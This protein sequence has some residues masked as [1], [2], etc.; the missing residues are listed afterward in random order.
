M[1]GKIFH[2]Y[3]WWFVS[4]WFHLNQLIGMHVCTSKYNQI[5]KSI[6]WSPCFIFFVICIHGN[7]GLRRSFVKK[8]KHH[9][10]TMLVNQPIE[11]YQCWKELALTFVSTGQCPIT[12]LS[13][14][15]FL[16]KNSQYLL[17]KRA[18]SCSSVAKCCSARTCRRQNVSAPKILVAKTSTP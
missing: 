2:N 12:K 13:S 1:V 6:Q 9:C 17:Q 7:E 16:R 5:S 15:K 11:K 18:N 10:E 4:L 14:K 8:Y 3:S